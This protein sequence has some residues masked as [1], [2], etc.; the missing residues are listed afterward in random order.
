MA[1]DVGL[2]KWAGLHL[3]R[4][5]L[6]EIGRETLALNIKYRQHAQIAHPGQDELASNV[7]P[8]QVL[9]CDHKLL[10]TQRRDKSHSHFR[11][12][13][14]YGLFSSPAYSRRSFQKR[15]STSAIG[16]PCRKQF[17]QFRRSQPWT[18]KHRVPCG[19]GGAYQKGP[20]RNTR[21]WRFLRLVRRGHSLLGWFQHRHGDDNTMAF[22]THLPRDA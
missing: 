12:S 2:G 14:P 16:K 10:D 18:T 9:A 17:P 1:S 22:C 7:A 11:R 15:K 3:R 19:D 13:F 6:T 4:S 5:S 21:S 20:A 8:V